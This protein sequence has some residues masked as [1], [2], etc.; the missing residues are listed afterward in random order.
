MNA[1]GICSAARW[2]ALCSR[3]GIE[4]D[5]QTYDALVSAHAEAHRAYHTLD[6]IAACL[7]HLDDVRDLADRPD[8][9]EMALWFHDAIYAP[10]SATNEEDSAAWAADWLQDKGM[11]KS[12]I[13]RI[14]HHILD[15]KSHD[16]PKTTDGQLMLDID[17]SILGTPEQVY[18][19]F[20][21]H[22][23]REYRRVPGF[24]F[25]KTRK[26][27]LEGFLARERLYNCGYFYESLEAQARMNLKR[28]ISKL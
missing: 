1:V 22:I 5:P 25:R 9:I 4:P 13:D 23:R 17:L 3:L 8:E 27:I 2:S 11:D 15:T 10:F 16:A 18:D 12:V 19:E 20:E 21:T 14:S 26:A 7:R 24:I 28:A 6:H